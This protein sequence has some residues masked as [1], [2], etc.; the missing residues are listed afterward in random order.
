VKN[1][2]IIRCV[3]ARVLDFWQFNILRHRSS[4]NIRTGQLSHTPCAE[5]LVN[6]DYPNPD[7]ATGIDRDSQ[8][9]ARSIYRSIVSWMIISKTRG[10]RKYAEREREIEI[11]RPRFN[12][13][14]LMEDLNFFTQFR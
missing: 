14:L 4:G 5:K 3:A 7:Y 12:I 13:E 10:I 6:A 8:V 1:D 11:L 2:H 9:T